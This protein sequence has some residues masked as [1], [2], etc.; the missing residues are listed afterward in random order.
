MK[1]TQ[2]LILHYYLL[3]HLAIL[4]PGLITCTQVGFYADIGVLHGKLGL[5]PNVLMDPIFGLK[6]DNFSKKMTHNHVRYRYFVFFLV[7]CEK[8]GNKIYFRANITMNHF[9]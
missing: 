9:P 7:Y 2:V 8:S 6:K 3:L 5:T 1:K 4:Y